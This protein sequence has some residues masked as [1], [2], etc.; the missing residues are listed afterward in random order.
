MV[1][2]LNNCIGCFTTA[3]GWDCTDRIAQ[4]GR[5]SMEYYETLPQGSHSVLV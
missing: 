4:E 1:V 5:D 2:A 3:A